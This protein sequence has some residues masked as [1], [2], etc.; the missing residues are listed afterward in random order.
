MTKKPL[1]NWNILLEKWEKQHKQTILTGQVYDEREYQ[2]TLT[3]MVY[4]EREY[5]F[6]KKYGYNSLEER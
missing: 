5:R 1:Y 6:A 3:G 2:T 4:E